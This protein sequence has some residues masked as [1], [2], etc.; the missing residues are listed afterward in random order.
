MQVPGPAQST[1][2]KLQVLDPEIQQPPSDLD[3]GLF[4]TLLPTHSLEIRITPLADYLWLAIV[5]VQSGDGGASVYMAGTPV[6][7]QQGL[8]KA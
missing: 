1:N 4:R 3:A 8:T 7:C 2:G 5:H 6:A